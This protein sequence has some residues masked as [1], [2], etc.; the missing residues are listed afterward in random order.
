MSKYLVSRPTHSVAKAIFNDFIL[1][2]GLKKAMR[3]DC[4]TEYR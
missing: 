2:Y 4:G 1:I 3:T